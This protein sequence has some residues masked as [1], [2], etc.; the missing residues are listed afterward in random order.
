VRGLAVWRDSSPTF[1]HV[2]AA[3][4]YRA[5]TVPTDSYL[6]PRYGVSPGL[7]A[8][9]AANRDARGLGLAWHPFE[10]NRLFAKPA[11]DVLLRVA[12]G[13]PGPLCAWIHLMDSHSPFYWGD[14]KKGPANLGGLRRSLRAVDAELARFLEDLAHARGRRPVVAIFGDHGEE[15]GEHGGSAHGSTVHA[16]QVRVGLLVGGE[17][18]PAG[19]FDAPVSISSLPATFLELAGASVPTTMTEP[20]LLGALRGEGPWPEVAVS[21]SWARTRSWVGYTFARHRL[22]VEPTHQLFELYDADADPYERVDL[23]PRQP[24][25]L[26]T[27]RAQA[28]RWDDRH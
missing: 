19:T 23:A 8:V 1:G 18:I 13:T 2:L 24:A 6:D 7:E 28:R 25:L 4:G 20:S 26:R 9:Y 16:E 12:K 22:L 10:R 15:L 3:R 14:G 17:G 5:V 27:L 11:L 21:E